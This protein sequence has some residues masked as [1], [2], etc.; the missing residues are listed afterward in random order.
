MFT[1]TRRSQSR[2]GWGTMVIAA[3]LAGQGTSAAPLVLEET[4]RITTPDPTYNWPLSIAIDGD[5]LLASGEKDVPSS[6]LTDNSTW[7]YQRQSNGSW[8]LVRRL[9]QYLA[10][11]PGD[12]PNIRV[13]MQG[14]V[15]VILKER[16]SWIFERSGSTWVAVP[17][18][19]ETDGMDA[20]INGGTI[21]VTSGHCSW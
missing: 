19:I 4:A 8:R 17:S 15:A 14:G 18:P 6:D 16:A 2:F 9:H 7:L 5:W 13:A 11:E 21:L 10:I 12:E 3:I 20:E 1:R